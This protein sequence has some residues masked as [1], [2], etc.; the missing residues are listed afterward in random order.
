LE[1]IGA[2]SGPP[3]KKAVDTAALQSLSGPNLSSVDRYNHL[4]DL[5]YCK[6][7]TSV[8][9]LSTLQ[10]LN[11]TG[12]PLI[13][14]ISQLNHIPK[15]VVAKCTGIQS[16][17]HLGNNSYQRYVDVSGTMISD[18]EI[19]QIYR[20]MATCSSGCDCDSERGYNQEAARE[21]EKV[22]P[23]E[24][25]VGYIVCKGCRR[26]SDE[27][28]RK[29]LLD[30]QSSRIKQEHQHL[31]QQQLKQEHFKT[32]TESAIKLPVEVCTVIS[33]VII[34]VDEDIRERCLGNQNNL[35]EQP[36]Q[37]LDTSSISI[38]HATF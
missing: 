23:D 34:K 32:S 30:S 25:E 9:H 20:N 5:S 11:V 35:D 7:L 18:E 14:D 26:V 24:I 19:S 2:L 12:C 6:K 28:F 10:E 8:N 21:D 1:N 38:L 22:N 31:H 16:F 37:S 27:C 33:T 29:I 36:I 13:S 3:L 15:L 17:G 4:I